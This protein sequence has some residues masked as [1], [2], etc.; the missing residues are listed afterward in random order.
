[1]ASSNK[2]RK[3]DGT[4]VTMILIRVNYL[5]NNMKVKLLHHLSPNKWFLVQAKINE[6]CLLSLES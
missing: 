1:M 5:Q 4:I 3:D 6:G 2:I